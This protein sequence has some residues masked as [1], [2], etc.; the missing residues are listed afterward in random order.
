MDSPPF[1][2]KRFSIEQQGVAHPVGTDGVLLGAWADVRDAQQVLD[3]GTGT[4]LIALMLAQRSAAHIT[5][6][7]I[8]PASADCAAR[9]F[10]ASPWAERLHL[11]R[12]SVQHFA[13]TTENQYDVIVSNP[14]FF[15]AATQSPDKA[16]RLGRHAAALPLADLLT[17]ASRLFAPK[18]R[19]CVILPP[20]EGQILCELAVPQ[21]LYWTHIMEVHAR[22]ARPA[23]RLLLQF[24]RAPHTFQKGKLHL[25]DALGTHYS[26]DFRQMTAGFYL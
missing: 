4:G 18:G 16:R 22:P 15:S 23:E 11:V 3:I 13:Q 1:H 12:S 8:H 10:A 26:D 20:T 9:N 14:P 21:G 17:C 19:L 6:V 24:E 2:F 7:E 5:A 25:H